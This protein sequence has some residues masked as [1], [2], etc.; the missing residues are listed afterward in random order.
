MTWWDWVVFGV[1]YV[2]FVAIVVGYVWT[3]VLFVTGYR[4]LRR[5]R[6]AP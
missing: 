6:S 4:Y 3:A 2:S 1:Y 5:R